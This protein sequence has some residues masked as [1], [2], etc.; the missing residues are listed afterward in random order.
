MIRRTASLRGTSAALFWICG[1]LLLSASS[2]TPQPPPPPAPGQPLTWA[3][4]H[5]LNVQRAQEEH[6]AR[7]SDKGDHECHTKNCM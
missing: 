2:C 5:E 4:Q 3:Q 1:G 6:D 7:A